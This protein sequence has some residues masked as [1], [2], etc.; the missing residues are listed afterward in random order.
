MPPK[1][2]KQAR[3]M[4]AVASG[5]VKKKSLSPAKA[6]EFVSGYSTKNLPKRKK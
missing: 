5:S 1:S 2:Q 4:R 3:F 6:A